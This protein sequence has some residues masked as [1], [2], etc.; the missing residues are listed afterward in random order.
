MREIDRLVEQVSVCERKIITRFI[1]IVQ[2]IDLS[3]ELVSEQT[4]E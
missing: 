4:R 2:V 1:L 3:G